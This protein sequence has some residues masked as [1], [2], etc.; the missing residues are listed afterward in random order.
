MIQRNCLERKQNVDV[1]RRNTMKHNKDQHTHFRTELVLCTRGP[2]LIHTLSQK[3][4]SLS[5]NMGVFLKV[6]SL[7]SKIETFQKLQTKAVAA[8]A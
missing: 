5:N 1:D 4:R 2:G 3:S 8:V 6:K 7:D